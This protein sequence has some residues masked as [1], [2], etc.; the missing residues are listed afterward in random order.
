MS[1]II[2]SG[3]SRKFQRDYEVIDASSKDIPEWLE[4]A[5][6]KWAED[7]DE[8]EFKKSR[9]YSYTS[10][11]KTNRD[12]ACK[13]AEVKTREKVA[14]EISVFIKNSFASA[15]EGDPNAK[16]EKLDEYVSDELVQEVQNQF[17]GSRVLA[18]YWEKRKFMKEM[19]AKNDWA[20]YTCSALVR[21][22]KDQLKKAFSR[23]NKVLSAK[24]KSTKT[25][26][27]VNKAV[28]KAQDEYLKI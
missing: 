28:E 5:P 18:T 21:I 9:Y 22:P 6:E 7:E 19:G 16:D 13:I 4:K 12:I 2:L 27:T 24:A 8:E 23:A 11:A 10:E 17:V 20:G 26:D 14:S 25:K 3:C 1:L 15:T